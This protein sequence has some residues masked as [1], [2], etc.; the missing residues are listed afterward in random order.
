MENTEEA[1]LL[2]VLNALRK[3]FEVGH[4]FQQ[5]FW[6]KNETCHLDKMKTCPSCSGVVC[7][8]V[9]DLM[10]DFF[11]VANLKEIVD[12]AKMIHGKFG[13]KLCGI[14]HTS[15]QVRQGHMWNQ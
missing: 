1:L 4:K 9:N 12:K 13:G 11:S 2:A 10:K 7:Q 8:R 15:A 5:I 14:S 3:M 6:K